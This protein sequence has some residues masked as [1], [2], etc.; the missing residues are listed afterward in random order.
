VKGEDGLVARIARLYAGAPLPRDAIGIGDDAAVVRAQGGG[1]L[2]VSTDLFVEGV[3]FDPR[4][5]PPT[6][7]G[8]KA[9][10]V[11]ASDI[12]AMGG[13][14]SGC[15]LSLA[16]PPRA[17]GRLVEAVLAGFS[18]EALEIG[19]P[20][21]GGDL[22]RSTSALVLD[23]VVLGRP[24]GRRPILRSGAKPP[25][26]LYVTGALGGS[27]A[28]LLRL[29]AGARPSKA[30]LEIPRG[31]PR[32]PGDDGWSRLDRAME[33]LS[34]ME[35][36]RPRPPLAAGAAFGRSGLPTAMMDISD[37]LAIDL[38]RLCKASGV[39]ARVHEEWVPVHPAARHFLGPRGLEA[40][41]GGG[42]DYELLLAAPSQCEA[43]LKRIA[44]RAGSDLIQIGEI[45]ERHQ[46]LRLVSRE[47]RAR[48]LPRVGFDHFAARGS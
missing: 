33:T 48:P 1:V 21:L 25:D 19:I 22:S 17:S 4:Y 18:G 12:G 37:G 15:L 30:L 39:G 41:L 27:G 36:L 23:V 26:R 10:A 38:H 44:R 47:G 2:L 6:F 31:R 9:L 32:P 40:A 34:L 8:H 42:E 16:V 20:L 14:P 43:R 11:A 13:V 29:K 45:A 46:G 7:V 35:H 3:H 5:V 28:G 24:A